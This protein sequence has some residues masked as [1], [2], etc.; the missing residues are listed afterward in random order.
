MKIT[1]K[2]KEYSLKLS[3]AAAIDL[4]TELGNNPVNVLFSEM[5]I[6]ES[7]ALPHIRTLAKIFYYCLKVNKDMTFSKAVEIMEEYLDTED[8]RELMMVLIKCLQES[9]LI[10]RGE[11]LPN[12]M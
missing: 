4:E 5:S 10:P 1:V 9:G 12:V 7:G 6:N 11:E 2:D 8:I 3:I